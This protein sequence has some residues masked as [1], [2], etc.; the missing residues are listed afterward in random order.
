[1]T[2]FQ[3]INFFHGIMFHHFHD[4]KNHKKGQGSIS[5]DDFYNLINF[6]GRKNIL[7][8]DIFYQKLKEKKLKENEVCFTFDDAIKCQIDV[9]LPVLEDLKIKSFFFVHTS[10][11]EGKHDYLEIFRHFRLNYFEDIN[12]FYSIFFKNLNKD[13][14]SF[15][16][17]NENLI[18]ERTKRYSFYSLEDIKFR[19]VRDIL[20]NK[21]DYE[22]HMFKL[23]D[24][25][26]FD[27][28]KIISSLFF[29]KN[30]LV[31][32]D[33]LGHCI[34][35]HS[36]SHPTLLEKLNYDEQKK[37][38]SQNFKFIHKILNKPKNKIF[39]CSHPLGSYNH[40]TLKILSELGIELAFKDNI[41]VE[42]DRGMKKINNSFLEIARR[43]HSEIIKSMVK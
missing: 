41:S 33:N 14:N 18:L 25:K 16:K 31:S 10:M 29:S 7:N 23:M 20:L 15:F 35:L 9:A 19:L 38:Y 30:D 27:Y 22:E 26:K 42:K 6:I 36:H 12:D 37:E 43:D 5:K 1:M 39:S 40:D 11:H 17:K 13:L 3:N 28:N 2:Y 24:I 8:A 32:L 21:K 4:E 34:G